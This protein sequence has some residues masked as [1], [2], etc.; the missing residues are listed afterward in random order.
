[1]KP[2]STVELGGVKHRPPGGLVPKKINGDLSGQ[3][4]YFFGG[5]IFKNI[6]KMPKLAG[7]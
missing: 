5:W 6:L 7:F 2:G 4:L 1:M 3:S